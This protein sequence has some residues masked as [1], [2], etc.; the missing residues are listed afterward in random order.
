LEADNFVL[1]G[2]MYALLS[3]LYAHH[4]KLEEVLT[5]INKLKES[6][7]DFP[8]DCIKIVK[9]VALLVKNDKVPG[10]RYLYG[11][12]LFSFFHL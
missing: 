12:F 10:K 2:G 3:E 7:P 11:F 8:L 4:D 6:E 1:T 9:I 5:T